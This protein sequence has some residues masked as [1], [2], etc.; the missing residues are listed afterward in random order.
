[1]EGDLGMKIL[2]LGSKGMLGSECQKVLDQEFEIMAPEKKDLDIVS[3]DKVIDKLQRSDPKIVLN[4]AAITDVDSC[5]SHREAYMVRKINVEG[6]RNL[7][8]GAA[9]F[10]C[11]IIH[12]SSEHVFSGEKGIPQPYFEDD[13]LDPISVY[14]KT[15][16]ESEIAI[17]DNLSDH[18]IIRSGWLYGFQGNNFVKSLVSDALNKKGRKSLKIPNDQYGSP[19]WAYR[20]ALQIRDLIR[21]DARG[22]YH[23]TSEGACS[24][25]ECAQYIVEKLNLKVSLQPC[26]TSDLPQKARRP[27]NCILENRLL[28]KQGLNIMPDWKEDLSAFLE[29][30]GEQLVKEAKKGTSS[31]D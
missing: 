20:L 6:P 12:I 30:F 11:K 18:L 31:K 26:D 29:Q 25:M 8:Q 16:M 21:A 14:G 3:W 7:A 24:R 5:E 4:C 28:K 17:K 13:P 19:T 10:S 9:R 15:K 22:T 1:L 2:L 27:L 23:A